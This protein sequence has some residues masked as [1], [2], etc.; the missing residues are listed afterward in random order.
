MTNTKNAQK[1]PSQAE[2]Q[3]RPAVHMLALARPLVS[4]ASAET[5]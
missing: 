4:P 2:R 5:S 1:D 3:T